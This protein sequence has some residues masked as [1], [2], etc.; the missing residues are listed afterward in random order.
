[1]LSTDKIWLQACAYI[2]WVTIKYKNHGTYI[3]FSF[4]SLPYFCRIE[5]YFFPDFQTSR[6]QTTEAGLQNNVSYLK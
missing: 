5:I 2:F 4:R 3:L 1:M 6:G